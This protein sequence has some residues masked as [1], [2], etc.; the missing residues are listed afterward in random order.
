MVGDSWVADVEGAR[1]VGIRAVHVWRHAHALSD[2]PEDV[3]RVPDLRP[4]PALLGEE[5][6]QPAEE[7]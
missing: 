2:P 5:L 3:V 6:R 7:R 4:L 1:A